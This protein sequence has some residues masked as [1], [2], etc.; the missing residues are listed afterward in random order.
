MISYLYTKQKPPLRTNRA[1]G[2][3]L[4]QQKIFIHYPY[5]YF[6]PQIK[7]PLRGFLIMKFLNAGIPYFPYGEPRVSS[8]SNAFTSVFEM[9]TGGSHL[10]KTPAKEV[11]QKRCASQALLRPPA[12]GLW[13]G[14]PPFREP[15][16][17]LNGIHAES[18]STPRLNALPRLH[19][20]PINV[21]VFDG[22][23][24]PNLGRGFALRC[25]QRLSRPNLA[26]R[27]FSWYQSR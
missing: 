17:C 24:I 3:Y 5:F 8:G 14:K 7:N 25:F 11:Y 13:T 22:L 21:V 12:G 18:I 26:T 27:H 9:G 20:E 2:L 10:S 15:R 16:S 4:L 19:L 1:D 6:Q 23:M